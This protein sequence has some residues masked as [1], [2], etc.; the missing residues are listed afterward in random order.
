MFKPVHPRYQALTDRQTELLRHI[1]DILSSGRSPLTAELQALMKVSRESSL[2]DLLLPLQRKGFVS[3][4]GGVRGRQRII[5]LTARAKVFLQVGAP[6]VGRITAGPLREAICESEEVVENLSDA[7]GFRPGDFLLRVD[8][9]SMVGDGIFDGDRVLLRP[10]QDVR[11]GEIA[12]VQIVEDA[13]QWET[14]LKRVYARPDDEDVELRP[15]NPNYQP[16]WVPREKVSIAGVFRGVLRDETGEEE[17]LHQAARTGLRAQ[18]R[19]N[20]N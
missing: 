2:A 7:V 18:S 12:A 6:V 10:N 4:T 19:M 9:D 11:L 17:A 15:S 16:L 14:T 3:V 20:S 8:G 5:E 13:E 1:G